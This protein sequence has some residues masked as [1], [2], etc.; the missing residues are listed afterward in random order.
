VGG[1][2]SN[3]EKMRRAVLLLALLTLCSCNH[4]F[5][6]PDNNFYFDPEESGFSKPE[7]V[8]FSS[9]DGTK[10]WGWYFPALKKSKGMIVQFHGNAENL[11][12]HYTFLAWLTHEGYDLFIFDYRGYG[13]SEGSPSQEG[14]YLDGK[15]AID[16]AWT[17]W[18]ERKK[19]GHFV[20]YGQSL[21]GAIAARAVCDSPHSKEV[22]LLVQDSTFSNYR[23]V[24]SG[25]L[26][27][28]WFLWP[29]SWLPYLLV[30]NAYGTEECLTKNTIPLLVIHDQKDRKV[31][32]ENGQTIFD[33]AT[34]PS[35]YFW[36]LNQGMHLG[37][38][39]ERNEL[40][41]VEFVKFLNEMVH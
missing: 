23:K 11:T 4:L 25:L 19:P 21:G 18:R 7:V 17:R 32:F 16:W 33:V 12:S 10:L 8:R 37:V 6:V 15:A 41:R 5:Y 35:K 36:K 22:T 2:E 14:T 29:I 39:T 20:V 13:Q 9:G 30:S 26:S 31:L 38:F 34:T 28:R 24:A 27:Q 3:V 1:D 40:Y